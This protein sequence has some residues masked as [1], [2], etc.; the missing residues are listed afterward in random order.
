LHI[1]M[2][3]KSGVRYCFFDDLKNLV[4]RNF[5]YYFKVAKN[6]T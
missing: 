6:V 3:E 4:S 5:Q 1:S 2:N